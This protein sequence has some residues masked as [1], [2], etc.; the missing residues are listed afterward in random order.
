MKL[1]YTPCQAERLREDG[2]YIPETHVEQ[3]ENDQWCQVGP[4][5]GRA[6]ANVNLWNQPENYN[7]ELG[8]WEIPYFFDRN[9]Y[10]SPAVTTQIK[11]KLAEFDEKTCVRMVEVDAENKHADRRFESVIKV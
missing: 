4:V 11:N 10:W 2:H 6:L 5:R 9:Q 3:V 8:M 7:P 1:S